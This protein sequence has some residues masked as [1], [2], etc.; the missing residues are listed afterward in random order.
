MEMPCDY[1]P[2]ADWTTQELDPVTRKKALKAYSKGDLIR[3][4]LELE[5]RIERAQKGE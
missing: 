3:Y 2:P 5:A 1:P 4:V